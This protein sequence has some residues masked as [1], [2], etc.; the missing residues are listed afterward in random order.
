MLNEQAL[1]EFDWRVYQNI[2]ITFF[3]F[4]QWLKLVLKYDKKEG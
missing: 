3:T 4:L 2:K 1:N